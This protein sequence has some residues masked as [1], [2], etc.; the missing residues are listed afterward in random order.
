MNSLHE[1]LGPGLKGNNP[2]HFLASLGT[3][4]LL[5][6]H[7]SEARMKWDLENNPFPIYQTTL[8]EK[9]FCGLLAEDFGWNEN[10]FKALKKS[11]KA[12]KPKKN[13]QNK[14]KN[15]EATQANRFFTLYPVI[16]GKKRIEDY[17][18]E[19]FRELSIKLVASQD[20]TKTFPLQLEILAAFGSDGFLKGE[21]SICPSHLSF[22]NGGSGQLLLKDF[23]QCAL[24]VS[25]I[26]LQKTFSG[27]KANDDEVTSLN[28]DPADQRSYALLYGDP[29][30]PKNKVPCNATVNALAFLGF[31]CFPSVP[32][33]K[34]LHTTGFFKK[35]KT[36]RWPLWEPF[37][38]FLTMQSL[39][40][41]NSKAHLGREPSI[42]WLES[43]RFVLNKRSFFSPSTLVTTEGG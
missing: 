14:G 2:L 8:D 25:P 9:N 43:E 10:K 17:T 1:H 31:S 42:L 39:L 33:K 3:F 38:T 27:E 37:I 6:L 22:S 26:S 7:D 29:G 20:T 36:F 41:A 5:Y 32:G 4:R 35:N 21:N 24:H 40:V 16:K 34:N 12:E 13:P 28:W 30:N 11:S 18:S 23:A 19:D 15:F